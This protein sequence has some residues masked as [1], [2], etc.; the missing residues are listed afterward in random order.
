MYLFF[1]NE[2]LFLCLRYK[3]QFELVHL[4]ICGTEKCQSYKKYKIWVE[5]SILNG[6]F[7]LR[8]LITHVC[9]P[10]LNASYI[11][12]INNLKPAFQ[13]TSSY[14]YLYF[15]YWFL[16]RFFKTPIFTVFSMKM[17]WLFLMNIWFKRE[18]FISR[19]V[20]ICN[21]FEKR[22]EYEK[23]TNGRLE[24]R[25]IERRTPEKSFLKMFT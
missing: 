17:F 11:L 12:L 8:N 5:N 3:A 15:G 24:K 6:I 14:K 1:I 25:Q 18:C 16:T 21:V 9:F 22:R 19:L 2:E 23:F 7:L 20:E 13:W 10:T 4:T